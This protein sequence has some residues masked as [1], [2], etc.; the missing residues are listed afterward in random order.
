MLVFRELL[1][2]NKADRSKLVSLDNSCL[3]CMI[4]WMLRAISKKARIPKYPHHISK[5]F[6]FF[7]VCS[8]GRITRRK[9]AKIILRIFKISWVY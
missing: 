3:Y 9:R 5:V 4:V 2:G 7:S 8:S 6:N 1:L